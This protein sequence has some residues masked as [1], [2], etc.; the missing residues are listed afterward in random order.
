MLSGYEFSK[1]REENRLSELSI[2]KDIFITS[3]T[4]KVD[5]EPS[6]IDTLDDPMFI[7]NGDRES[8]KIEAIYAN[9]K[10]SIS[11]KKLVSLKKC[12]VIGSNL[13]NLDN[14]TA[15]I[16]V[17]GINNIEQIFKRHLPAYSGYQFERHESS[18]S[19][20]YKRG[21]GIAPK[22]KGLLI[23]GLEGNNYGSFLFRLLPQLLLV[24]ELNLDF[25]YLIVPDRTSWLMQALTLLG[26]HKPVFC[27]AEIQG[28]VLS[29]LIFIETFDNL[30]FLSPFDNKRI[31]EFAE[32]F[33]KP[34]GFYRED[35][36]YISR[37]I[38][39]MR[40][41]KTRVLLNESDVVATLKKAGFKE[42]F[43]ETQSL[44]GQMSALLGAKNVV[45][46]SGSGLLNSMFCNDG[47]K[48]I[49][50]EVYVKCTNQHASIYTSTGKKYGFLFGDPFSSNAPNLTSHWTVDRNHLENALSML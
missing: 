43:L 10:R 35:N 33:S 15:L 22:G 8:K 1:K 2:I 42:C 36:I 46:A 32:S 21:Y 6:C 41:N 17:N 23:H 38:E 25:D 48:I 18:L 50:L 20:F 26:F 31:K 34:N 40:I 12:S 13:I 3:S 5:I 49:E 28:E 4:D 19:V 9:K 29:E 14:S 24:K 11:S 7:I 39:S 45:G 16:S 30:G 27:N 44:Q 37:R 47:S